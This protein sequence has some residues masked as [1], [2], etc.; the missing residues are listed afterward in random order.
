[1]RPGG[2][3]KGMKGMKGA[4]DSPKQDLL[5]VGCLRQTWAV[6]IIMFFGC[7]YDKSSTMW[8][9]HWGR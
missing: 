5:K 1:M 8:S 3:G 7:P 6:S 4:W 2:G 9:L